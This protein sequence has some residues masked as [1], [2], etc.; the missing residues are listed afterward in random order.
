MFFA[1]PARSLFV[2]HLYFCFVFS[3]ETM[4]A[5]RRHRNACR[6]LFPARPAVIGAHAD[7]PLAKSDK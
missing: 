7:A 6:L 1:L 3:R 4:D 2:G 5:V